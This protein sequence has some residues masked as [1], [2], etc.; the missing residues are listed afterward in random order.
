MKKSLLNPC[1]LNIEHISSEDQM[2]VGQI[3]QTTKM[4]NINNVTRTKAYLD[5]YLRYPE[6]HWAFLGH[7]VSRNG[8]WNMTDLKGDLLSRLMSEKKQEEFFEFLERGNWLIFQDAF[9]QFLLYEESIRRGRSLFYLLPYLEISRYMEVIWNDFWLRGDSYTLAMAQVVNEQSYLEARMIQNPFYKEKVLHTLEF[10]L[11]DL[12]SFNQILFPSR[13]GAKAVLTGMTIH[14]FGSLHERIILGRRLYQLLFKDWRR[15]KK[16]LNW[17]MSHTHSGSRKDYWPHIFNDV[18]EGVPGP[19][20]IRRLKNCRLIKGSPKLYSP[21]L[22]YA[23]PNMKHRPAEPGDWFD[24]P[25]VVVYLKK[26]DEAI[27]GEITGDYCETL[28]NL[29]LA[30]LAK[31]AIFI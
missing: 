17:C 19:L 24:D 1:H 13:N 22:E 28:Q 9:P 11:Q 23:W 21:L 25:N 27:D 7:L 18:N 29:E 3:R 14:Q 20:Q 15:H 6:I 10:V 12:L 26:N 4:L 31:K 16:I 30:V 2:I 5:F 8:G